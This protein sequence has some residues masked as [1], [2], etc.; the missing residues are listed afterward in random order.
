MRIPNKLWNLKEG[1]QDRS[2]NE[3]AKGKHSWI[4]SLKQN[5]VQKYFTISFI[6]KWVKLWFEVKI[7]PIFWNFDDILAGSYMFKVNNRNTRT[8]V[9]NMFKVNNKDTKTTPIA[10]W[11]LRRFGVFIINFEHISHLR[12]SVSVVNFELVNAGWDMSWNSVMCKKTI[13][14]K[15]ANFFKLLFLNYAC[16]FKLLFMLKTIRLIN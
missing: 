10:F 1:Q 4:K 2:P 11:N 9:W 12:S 3:L 5:F 7:C 13:A 15:Y 6:E 8:K 16:F 14:V